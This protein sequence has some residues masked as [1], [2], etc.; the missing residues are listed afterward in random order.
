M[1]HARAPYGFGWDSMFGTAPRPDTTTILIHERFPGLYGNQVF[2]RSISP[3]VPESTDDESF[4]TNYLRAMSAASLP[5]SRP[6]FLHAAYPSKGTSRG[7]HRTHLDSYP[8]AD[9]H[10]GPKPSPTPAVGAYFHR[11]GPTGSETLRTRWRGE[12]TGS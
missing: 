6:L 8:S 4:S 10:P 12:A 5:R 11:I 9:S 7:K 3:V 2:R 1:W